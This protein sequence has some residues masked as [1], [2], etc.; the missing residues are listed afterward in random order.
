M[1]AAEGVIAAFNE[2]DVDEPRPYEITKPTPYGKTITLTS[3]ADSTV[4]VNWKN[5]LR[6]V[7]VHNQLAG[8][9]ASLLRVVDRSNG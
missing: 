1:Q 5:C 7:P 2:F 9:A 8:S 4:L 3:V 6:P